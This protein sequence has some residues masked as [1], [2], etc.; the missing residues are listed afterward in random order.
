[1]NETKEKFYK[2]KY[3]DG[4]IEHY[5]AMYSV[6]SKR[7]SNQDFDAQNKLYVE[8]EGEKEF[9]NLRNEVFKAKQQADMNWFL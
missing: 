1:M 5:L 9:I 4:Y 6:H 8:C 7:L 2:E 3:S